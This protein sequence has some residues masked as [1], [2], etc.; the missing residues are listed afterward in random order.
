LEG[1][2]VVE[3]LLDGGSEVCL[4][5]R[6]TF[7]QLQLPIDTEI[8]W[9]IHG[10]DE[11]VREEVE[12]KGVIGVCHEVSISVGG[13]NVVMPVFVVE[14]ANAAL[15]LGRPWERFVRAEYVNEED[16]SLTVRIRSRDGRRIVKFCAAPANHERNRSFA[17]VTE[18][19]KA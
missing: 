17:R 5:P 16:G 8:N 1:E 11:K 10:Y 13:I 7:D 18:V 2:L 4:M 14:H 3:A 12:R 15:F 6:A 19:G 9:S